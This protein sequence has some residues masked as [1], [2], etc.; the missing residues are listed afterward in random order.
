MSIVLMMEHQFIATDGSQ[1]NTLNVTS[2]I[3]KY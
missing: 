3:A 2:P 1:K